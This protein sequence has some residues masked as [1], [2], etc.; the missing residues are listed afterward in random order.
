MITRR[1][2]QQCSLCKVV[3]NV[4]GRKPCVVFF[5]ATRSSECTVWHC[6]AAMDARAPPL[7]V[8]SARV[9][10]R[11]KLRVASREKNQAQP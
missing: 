3:Y 5:S 8:K 6:W 7:H 10:R 1:W 9:R 2:K 4:A 11:A